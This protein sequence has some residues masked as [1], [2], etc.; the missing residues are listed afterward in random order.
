[1]L[2]EALAVQLGTGKVHGVSINSEQMQRALATPVIMRRALKS[3]A[4]RQKFAEWSNWYSARL[5]QKFS[6]VRTV[7]TMEKF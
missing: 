3:R 6:P 1:M 7:L 2:A 4:Y 5:K